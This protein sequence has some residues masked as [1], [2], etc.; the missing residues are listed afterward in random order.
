[1]EDRNRGLH[2]CIMN[3]TS[4]P[5]THCLL[6]LCTPT[7]TYLVYCIISYSLHW[8]I[9]YQ[10][11]K[12]KTISNATLIFLW[13]QKKLLLI[14]VYKFIHLFLVWVIVHSVWGI[15][16]V[17]WC[18][19]D[20]NI[21]NSIHVPNQMQFRN[22][23]WGRWDHVEARIQSKVIVT[24]NYMLHFW[25]KTVELIQFFLHWGSSLTRSRFNGIFWL[26]FNIYLHH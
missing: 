10:L 21:H 6:P 20:R 19:G 23:Y 12:N 17:S 9:I 22:T 11:N 8:N 26:Y 25:G 14:F 7:H 13:F 4:W 2:I 24:F 18:D 3:R 16:I 1:M 5:S 15:S